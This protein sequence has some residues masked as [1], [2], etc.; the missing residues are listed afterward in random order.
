MMGY[1]PHTLN[2]TWEEEFLS[3]QKKSLVNKTS[4]CM[5]VQ[6]IFMSYAAYL[7]P[8][9]MAVRSNGVLKHEFWS[10]SLESTDFNTTQTWIAIFL[11]T[12][13]MLAALISM[14]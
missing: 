9:F 11:K 5:L 13:H 12:C 4:I 10:A 6:Y 8:T 2:L 14:M 3:I 1:G 7:T